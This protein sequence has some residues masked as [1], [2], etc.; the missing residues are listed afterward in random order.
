MSELET[1]TSATPTEATA[2]K[3]AGVSAEAFSF[4]DPIPVLDRRELLDYV[5]CVQMDRW[6]E[7]PVSFDGLARTY[8]A[9]VHHSSPIAV[10]RNILTSTFIPHPLLSQQAFSRFVQDYLVFGNAYLEKRTSRLGGILSLEPS[11]AKYTRRGIDLETYW[12]VQYGITT[13]PYEFTPGSV[14][15][16]L[17]PDINQEIYGLPGYLSA[18]PSALLNESATLFRRKYYINGSH[19]G[20]IMYMTDAAQNQEDVNNIR[21]AMKS[22]KG[23]GNFRNLFMYSPNG[24]KDGIQI[25]PLSEV[26]AKDE[27]LNIKNVSRDDMMAAHRVPPQMMGIMPNNVG[28]FGDIE[29]ASTVFVRNELLP[30]QKM[31]LGINDWLNDDIINFS[32]YELKI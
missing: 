26:A 10:K 11:L 32:E 22:A 14:F 29:K 6:Y 16:L 9:A 21:Q 13:Q 27:F 28:G 7:P 3:N 30:L 8:R 17:E 12:F 19:A 24:K 2:P 20:F 5:E 23:P 4:G 15:H 31:F 1:L 18:I 25:I